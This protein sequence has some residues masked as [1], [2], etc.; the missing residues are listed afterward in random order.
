VIVPKR[1]IYGAFLARYTMPKEYTSKWGTKEKLGFGFVI[2]HDQA[3]RELPK[4]ADAFRLVPNTLFFD[5]KKL[6]SSNLVEYLY[7]LRGGRKTKDEIVSASEI[8]DYDDFIGR[9]VL[10]LAEPGQNPDADGIYYN[11]ILGIDPIDTEMHAAMKPLLAK[12]EIA[13]NEKSALK[14]VKSPMG[15]HAEGAVA[16]TEPSGFSNDD[17]AGLEAPDNW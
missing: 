4:Y 15:A 11:N 12:I 9:P 1:G 7:A 6:T 5:A 13:T 2:T 3:Y 10:L 16:K 14:Y 17:F 8:Y